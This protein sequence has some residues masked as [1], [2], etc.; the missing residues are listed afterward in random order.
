MAHSDSQTG[1][2][3]TLVVRPG[4]TSPGTGTPP[5]PGH[6]GH[7]P[8]SGLELVPL[9]LLAVLVLSLGATLLVAARLLPARFVPSHVSTTHSRRTT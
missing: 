8:F 2:P 6:H 5:P 4:A 1:T 9:L 7:L 3:V